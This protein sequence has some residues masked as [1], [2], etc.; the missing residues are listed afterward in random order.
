MPRENLPA[1]RASICEVDRNGFVVLV[2]CR[3]NGE[4]CR[5]DAKTF[6]NDAHACD[7]KSPSAPSMTAQ[8]QVLRWVAGQKFETFAH[9]GMVAHADV[10]FI[11]VAN[12]IQKMKLVS[13]M[14]ADRGAS[15][16]FGS[17]IVV[18][19]N[20]SYSVYQRVGAKF[21]DAPL[22]SLLNECN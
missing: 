11:S 5:T 21:E 3:G 2:P 14:R 17:R 8:Q 18:K 10:Q 1:I 4:Y 20:D 6:T 15:F 9:K 7:T 19:E 16:A 22:L 12:S 13:L